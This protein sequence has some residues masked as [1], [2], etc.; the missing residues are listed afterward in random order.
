METYDCFSFFIF[1][2]SD[3][4]IEKITID[5]RQLMRKLWENWS[6]LGVDEKTKL[7][8]IIKLHQIEQ[9]FH[10][11]VMTETTLKMKRL[12]EEIESKRIT[13]YFDIFIVSIP[14]L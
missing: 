10:N 5:L 7:A 3:E 8:N 1:C 11:E 2:F 4:T 9:D 12:Q 13:S 14:I 6:H